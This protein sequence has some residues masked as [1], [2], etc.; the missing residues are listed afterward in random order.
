M[1]TLCHPPP[2]PPRTPTKLNIPN[3]LARCPGILAVL[4]PRLTTR[5]YGRTFL[6]SLPPYPRVREIDACI[7]F[8]GGPEGQA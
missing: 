7:A 5:P 6:A 8:F 3:V 2:P 4:D 1:P